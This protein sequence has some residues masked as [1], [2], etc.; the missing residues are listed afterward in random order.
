MGISIKGPVKEEA[1]EESYVSL[2]FS[3]FCSC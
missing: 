3:F 1:R 2:S